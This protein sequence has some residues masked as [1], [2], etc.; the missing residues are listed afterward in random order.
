ML[1]WRGAAWTGSDISVRVSLALIWEFHPSGVQLDLS[2]RCG[3]LRSGGCL[4]NISD[5][6]ELCLAVES[7]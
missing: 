6:N 4:S 3:N 2:R 1:H 5:V 7:T